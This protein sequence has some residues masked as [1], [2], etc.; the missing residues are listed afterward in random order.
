MKNRHLHLLFNDA[1]QSVSVVFNPDG[2]AYTYL[3]YQP[4]TAGQPVV[5]S[6]SGNIDNMDMKVAYAVEDSGPIDIDWDAD[7]DYKYVVTTIDVDQWQIELNAQSREILAARGIEKQRARNTMRNEIK[8]AF[9]G[10]PELLDQMLAEQKK[11]QNI[12]IKN[13]AAHDEDIK[14]A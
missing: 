7:F 9:E 10:C 2:K 12:L 8:A 14:D 5:I 6:Q 1:I 13:K 4:V 3:T 11:S